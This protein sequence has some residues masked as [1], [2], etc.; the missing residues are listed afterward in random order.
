MKIKKLLLIAL[1]GVL[2]LFAAVSCTEDSFLNEILKITSNMNDT[3]DDYSKETLSDADGDIQE[4]AFTEGDYQIITLSDTTNNVVLFNRL[5][6]E[7]MTYHDLIVE[8]REMIRTQ[9]QGIRE[10]VGTLKEMNY[11]I[12]DDDKAM[13][14]ERLETL[15]TIR[16]DL[17]GTLGQAYQRIYELRGTYT[18]DNLPDIIVVYQEVIEVLKYRLELFTQARLELENIGLALEDY[19]E[20]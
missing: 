20:E 13:L 15:R 1:I 5:R 3:V 16:A 6:L 8:Q 11:I 14:Q 12:L 19:L 2:T 4:V 17:E 10:D 7:I 18:R 9:F